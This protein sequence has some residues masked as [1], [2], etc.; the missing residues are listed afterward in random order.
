[1]NT[2]RRSFILGASALCASPVLVSGCAGRRFAANELVRVAL[3]GCGRIAWDFEVPNVIACPD[4]AR[5]VAVCDLDSVRANLMKRRIE[6]D[7]RALGDGFRGQTVD[8]YRDY[9]EMLARKDIDAVMICLPDFWHA[10]VASTAICSGKSVW[11]QKP[12]T[13]TIREGRILAN[14]ARRY[15]TV[16]QVGSQQ[17]S[18]SNF[19]TVVKAVRE[20]RLGAIRRVEVGVSKDEPGG[21]I[22][23][24]P[25]PKTFDYETWLGPT[26]PT[27]PYNQTR[28]H[29]QGEGNIQERP[30]WITIAPY[31]W[32]MITNWGAHHV[33]VAQWG[34]GAENSGPD[35]V[36]G[37]CTWLDQTGGK[38]WNVHETYD[39]HYSYFGGKTD[40]HVCNKYQ[41]GVK[42]IGEKGDW[43]F[44]SRGSAK[45]T[46]SD[47]DIP[48]K[49][50]ELP[51]VAASCPELLPELD[52]SFGLTSARAM[53]Q[54]VRNWLT[55][56]LAQDPSL[57]RT[58]AERAHRSTSACSLGQ[59]CMTLGCG[60]KDGFSL[61]WDPVHETTGLAE[62]DALMKPLAR[63]KFDL[64]INLSE[65][66]LDL[67]DILQDGLS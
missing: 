17:R 5:L 13:Q 14:L 39:L 7:Y 21:S 11:L 42:F 16:L 15:N 56:V 12:F 55:A 33:D 53:H 57:T 25:V 4:L 18:W 10:L 26:D 38:L 45:V 24:E 50:G 23:A 35:S 54:H 1:M 41:C 34:L 47:P 58:S 52:D 27:V 29:M 48:V 19:G 32:G 67:R 43:L 62:A 66:G 2:N 22:I 63:D 64:R 37:T 3:V 44:C 30:G 61:K 51:G 40:V 31:G 46:A 65:F 9:K 59:M 49:P 6:G 28:C 36:S 20:G 60:R 8:V